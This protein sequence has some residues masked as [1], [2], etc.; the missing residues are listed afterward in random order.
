MDTIEH[1]LPPS[2]PSPTDL[3]QRILA[4]AARL[5]VARGYHGLSM[6]EIA[7]AV[8]VSKA[9]LYYHFKDKEDLFLA[10]L[11]ADLAALSEVVTRARSA[12]A[13]AR[14]QVSALAYGL[15][16]RSPEQRAMV[17]LAN[18]E[19][20]HISEAA[21][22]DFSRVYY[23]AFISR[24]EDMLHESMTRGE[25]RPF[26]PTTATWILLGMLYPFF[27]APHPPPPG[28]LDLVV[29][30]FFDGAAR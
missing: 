22:A 29:S 18:Q 4:E 14:T 27:T 6:R 7:E 15:M 5:F 11:T 8:H 23:T 20:I 17:R 12:G 19:M 2:S 3:R 16:A 21:R 25:L 13:T 30:I 10:I 28:A 24:I 1:C 9:G 26:D